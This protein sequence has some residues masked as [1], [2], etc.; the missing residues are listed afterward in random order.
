MKKGFKSTVQREC[1]DT[2]VCANWRTVIVVVSVMV[3]SLAVGNGSV[4]AAGGITLH[5]TKDLHFGHVIPVTPGA[6]RI[7]P[8]SGC[9]R[10]VEHGDVIESG[11]CSAATFVVKGEPHFV[12]HVTLPE[13]SVQM[14]RFGDWWLGGPGPIA[15]GFTSA[16]MNG[17]SLDTFGE[18]TLF[19]GG[20]LHIAPEQTDELYFGVLEVIV[21]YE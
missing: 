9:Q 12:Y 5:W 1:R 2:P 11:M 13:P 3:A 15:S 21:E 7:A 16:S 14:P 10:I 20:T 19:I 4:Q 17:F 18:D 6:L 8:G